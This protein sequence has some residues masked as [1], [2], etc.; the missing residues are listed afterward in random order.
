M[1]VSINNNQKLF[2]DFF[3]GAADILELTAYGV[4]DDMP[5]EFLF[6]LRKAKRWWPNQIKLAWQL[7]KILYGAILFTVWFVHHIFLSGGFFHCTMDSFSFLIIVCLLI[8]F[9]AVVFIIHLP[10]SCLL[11]YQLIDNRFDK[12]SIKNYPLTS[13]LHER[14]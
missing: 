3:Y 1:T 5:I 4:T 8:V 14:E 6:C 9:I 12:Y 11:A 13:F 7:P 2:N 10:H